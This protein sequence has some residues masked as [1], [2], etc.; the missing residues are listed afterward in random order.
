MELIDGKQIAQEIQAELK[1]QI[2][3]LPGRPPCLAVILVGDHA[4]SH[5]YV[6]RKMA[7]CEEVGIISIRKH[8]PMTITEL[9]LLEEVERLNHNPDVDGILVQ[10][11]LPDTINPHTITN[12]VDPTKDVDGLHPLNI[13]KLLLHQ[14]GGFAPCTP[15]GVMTLLAK[16][17]VEV[18]GRQA[19]VIGRSHLVGKPMAALLLQSTPSGNATVTVAHRHSTNLSHLCQQA[20]ILISAV[21]QPRLIT[22][23]MVKPGA[24]VIDVGINKIDTDAGYKIVGD[25]AFD[26]VAPLCSAI[27]PVPGGVGPMTIAMLL[28]NTLKSL[29]SRC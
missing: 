19:L 5:I 29:L 17:K 25:V 26:E 23:E 4:P 20:D 3:S 2:R 7:A 14:T 24:V 27:T 22:K 13:G 28:S 10:L 21:G 16:K 11:P 1:E 8:F 18:T 9:E 15:L 12:A 6:K